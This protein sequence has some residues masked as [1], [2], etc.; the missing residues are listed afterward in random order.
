MRTHSFA[1]WAPILYAGVMSCGVA[2]TLQ[3]IGQKFTPPATA[4]LI[5]ST[6]SVFALLS[7]MVLTGTIPTLR[8]GIGCAL[9]LF[10]VL[11]SK[12]PIGRRAAYQAEN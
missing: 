4:S 8:E 1:A 2:Y 10:A 12:S 9:M 6:E 11:L 5:M 7:A 3:I